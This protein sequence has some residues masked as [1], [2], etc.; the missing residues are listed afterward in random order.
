MQFD[1]ETERLHI[2]EWHPD[3]WA[4]LLPIA[5]D[6]SVMRYIADG[7]PWSEDRVRAVI[8]RQIEN[9][10][11]Y[12]FCLGALIYKQTDEVI[13][14]AGLQRLGDTGEIEVGWW[15]ARGY[16]GKGI[17]TEVGGALLRFAFEQARL[18]RVVAIAHVDNRASIAVMKKIGM[19]F[20]RRMRRGDIGFSHPA[21]EIVMYSIS[22][23]SVCE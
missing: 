9:A 12:G 10:R 2:R 22:N 23:N 5:S 13:G 14:L 6:E 17:A 20:E 18:K 11:L 3:E 15:I 21:L 7:A 8:S 4:A 16:W 19:E 1:I